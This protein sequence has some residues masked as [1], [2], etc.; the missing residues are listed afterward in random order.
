MADM[1]TDEVGFELSRIH[2]LRADL[3]DNLL[4][5]LCKHVLRHPVQT[6]CS[7]QQHYFCKSCILRRLHSKKRCPQCDEV[8]TVE[9]LEPYKH[10]ID[11]LGELK[12]RC[13]NEG[14]D[15]VT[16]IDELE[17]HVASCGFTLVKCGGCEVMV[18]RAELQQHE[19]SDCVGRIVEC[20]VFKSAFISLACC[21]K[22]Q[23]GPGKRGLIPCFTNRG[24]SPCFTDRV[25]VLQIAD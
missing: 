6:Q 18:N 22:T 20:Q 9:T 21:I 15:E 16:T 8:L 23:T 11:V 24:P 10:A 14:C 13:N 19:K 7:Q 4:C 2:G 25:R 12:I 3:P 17:T 5:T 1:P